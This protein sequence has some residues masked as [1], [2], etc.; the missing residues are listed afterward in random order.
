[1]APAKRPAAPVVDKNNAPSRPP[2]RAATAAAAAA[3]GRPRAAKPPPRRQAAPKAPASPRP[4][5]D[6][7]DNYN[8]IKAAALARVGV[9][10][11]AG[12]AVVVQQSLHPYIKKL[13]GDPHVEKYPQTAALPPPECG[14]LQ[15]L[16]DLGCK[17]DVKEGGHRGNFATIAV[18]A[19]NAEKPAGGVL[20]M[21]ELRTR[22]IRARPGVL[23]WLRGVKT[24]DTVRHAKDNAARDRLTDSLIKNRASLL[25][26]DY[27]VPAQR[28]R[29][30]VINNR[31]LSERIADDEG[32]E[33][34]KGLPDNDD[35]DD[36]YRGTRQQQSD[37]LAVFI[38]GKDFFNQAALPAWMIN[39]NK[40]KLSYRMQEKIRMWKM[41][42][43]AE[44][45]K[46]LREALSREHK[47]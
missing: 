1:M 8:N 19:Y 12:R 35:E 25:R 42:G 4:A 45:Q 18:P 23:D 38:D 33:V 34:P 43:G 21:R 16:L 15:G 40:L 39:K 27:A 26:D 24:A 29:F 9:L 7:A 13:L 41:G 22:Q 11:R 44:G 47:Q 3:I 31:Y 6:A 14:S 5:D 37:A 36:L 32:K 20:P 2:Q 28:T 46:A 17:V 30:I 10:R